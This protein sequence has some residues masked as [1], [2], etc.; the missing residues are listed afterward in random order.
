M[1]EEQKRAVQDARNDYMIEQAKL[2]VWA[3]RMFVALTLLG[4]GWK[5]FYVPIYGERAKN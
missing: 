1:N 4:L 3:Y 5:F 2:R